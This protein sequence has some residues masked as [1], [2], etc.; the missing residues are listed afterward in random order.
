MLNFPNVHSITEQRII[1]AVITDALQEGYS[2]SIFD[3][4]EWPYKHLTD[5]QKIAD[6]VGRSD[7]TAFVLWTPEGTRIGAIQFMHGNITDV[8]VDYS[9]NTETTNVVGNACL[10][11]MACD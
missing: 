7:E 11:A 3:G 10:I 9:N 1:D 2:I 6:K 8:L 5:A 4:K